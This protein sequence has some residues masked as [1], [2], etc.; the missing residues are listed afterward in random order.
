MN[1]Y[2]FDP[3]LVLRLPVQRRRKEILEELF[4]RDVDRE[5]QDGFECASYLLCTD[6]S[7]AKSFSSR[8]GLGKM[9]HIDVK[10][11][12]LQDL[13]KKG[14]IRLAKVLGDQNPADLFTKYLDR[15]RIKMLGKITGCDICLP[16]DA[17][18]ECRYKPI[19]I[20]ISC[21]SAFVLS[22]PMVGMDIDPS[23]FGSSDESV[24]ACESRNS[25]YMVAERLRA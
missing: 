18:G 2:H 4:E 11:L 7:A 10:H 20:D 6:S 21:V 5:V 13:V 17:E 12:W 14:E 15:A 19:D 9:R 16:A 1:S 3:N 8:R 23:P 24:R 25:L 22:E